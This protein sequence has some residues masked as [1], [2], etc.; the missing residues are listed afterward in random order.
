MAP[1]LQIDLTPSARSSPT[2]DFVKLTVPAIF[3]YIYIYLHIS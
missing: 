2:L 1:W 3:I